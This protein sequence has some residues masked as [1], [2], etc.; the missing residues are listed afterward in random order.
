[1]RFDFRQADV[2]VRAGEMLTESQDFFRSHAENVDDAIGQFSR[3][4]QRISQARQD[5]VLD[6]QAVDDDVDGML[7]VLIQGNIV[8]QEIDFAVDA[9]ADIAVL[10]QF[11]QKFLMGPLAAVDDRGHDH[12]LFAFAEGHDSIGHLLDSLLADG[13]AAFRA[14]RFADAG[15]EQAQVIVDFRNRPDGRPGIAARRLLV[16]GNSRRQAFNVIDIGL[17][18][19]AQELPGIGR[20]RFDIATLAFGVNRIKSQGR[21]ARTGQARKDDELVPGNLDID[22]L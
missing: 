3:R 5:A 18:H 20:Q 2:A 10:D 6:D 22:V 4:F 17:I 1:M 8:G 13:L 14:I 12:D 11:G 7:L 21:L 15:I 9:D 19:L 16:D